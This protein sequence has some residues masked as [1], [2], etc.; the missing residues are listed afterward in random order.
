MSAV[1]L[2]V[3]ECAKKAGLEGKLSATVNT[4]CGNSD[5]QNIWIGLRKGR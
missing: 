1:F 5:F 4:S 3:D 2:S